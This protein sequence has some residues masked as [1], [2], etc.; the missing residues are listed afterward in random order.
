MQLTC[1]APTGTISFVMDAGSTGI[2]PVFAL[3]TWKTL[4]EG[5]GMWVVAP[6]IAEAFEAV[7]GRTPT[8]E[9]VNEILNGDIDD[10]L[11]AVIPTASDVSWQDHVAMMASVQRYVCGAISKTVNMPESASVQDIK[12]VYMEAWKSGVK[13]IAVYR[14]QSKLSQPLNVSDGD[15]NEHDGVDSGEVDGVGDDVGGGWNGRRKLPGKRKGYTQKVSIDSQ[16]MYIR[17]GEFDDGTLGELFLDMG[18]EGGAYGGLLSAFAKAVS[19]GLQYGVPL[20]VF[21]DS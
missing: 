4:A 10:E 15:N 8:D 11:R 14:D 5:G 2:E 18:K 21:A 20:D 19:I 16:S 3:K 1:I 13:C 7:H 6:F 17:T 12:D 9:E